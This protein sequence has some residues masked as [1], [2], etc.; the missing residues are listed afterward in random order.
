M[1][2]RTYSP[3]RILLLPLLIAFSTVAVA[4]LR[5]V[6]P[7][8]LDQSAQAFL[9]QGPAGETY[10]SWVD[11]EP[12]GGHALRTSR[13]QEPAGSWTKPET[14]ATGRNWFINWADFP[15]VAV[16]A[17]G[18]LLAHWLARPAG[19]GKWGYGIHVARRDPSTGVW[20]EKAGLAIDSQEDYAG[21]LSFVTRGGLAGAVYLAPPQ[22]ANQPGE[23]RKTVRFARFGADGSLLADVELDPD[24]CSCCQTAVA[25]TSRGL[26]AAYRDHLPGEIRD[27]S[28]VRLIDGVW[29]APRTLNP[30][31]WKINGCP[32]EGPSIATSGSHVAIAWLTRAGGE[33]KLQLSFSA[34]DGAE[35]AKPVRIDNGNPLGRPMITPLDSQSDL[36]VWVEKTT[37]GN[38]DV[39]IRRAF[40]DGRLGQSLTIASVAA[41]RGVGFPKIAI[42]GGRILVAWR[43]DRVRVSLLSK[44][45]IISQEVK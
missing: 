28:V 2:K 43:D 17:N 5:R 12:D 41:G 37:G 10:L 27:I 8:A 35:F 39:R 45:E 25:P 19:A 6:D 38:A 3:A 32:T 30:D 7:P 9:A 21:F 11:P 1:E 36:L 14:I 23:H 24:V 33:A 22:P 44:Q 20:S 40:R 13:W 16:R 34:N 26:I 18:G 31:G 29:T 4:E 42:T 15:A